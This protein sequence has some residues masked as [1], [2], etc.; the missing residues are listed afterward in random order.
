MVYASYN[1]LVNGACKKQRSHHWGAPSCTLK[2]CSV[3]LVLISEAHVEGHV[4]YSATIIPQK[5]YRTMARIRKGP[6]RV[7]W[8][9]WMG[10]RNP[11]HQLIGGQHPI[12]PII[13]RLSTKV[14]QDFATI[15][16]SSVQ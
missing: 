8:K 3:F 11:N 1:E 9:Y 10:Q 2:E 5:A 14:M 13:Y 16:S 6:G 15:H 4:R 12:Y 7:R